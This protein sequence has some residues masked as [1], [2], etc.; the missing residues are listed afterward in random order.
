M[1]ALWQADLSLL[2]GRASRAVPVPP[3]A[4]GRTTAAVVRQ[5]NRGGPRP[6]GHR[7]LAAVPPARLPA[8][9]GARRP[10]SPAARPGGLIMPIA[11]QEAWEI[12]TT[13]ATGDD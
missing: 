9:P 10:S 12:A 1:G 2:D 11:E 5:R 6:S 13:E 8:S 3:L 4:R 7:S